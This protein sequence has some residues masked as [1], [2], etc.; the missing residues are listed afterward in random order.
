LR[1]RHPAKAAY[2]DAWNER[3]VAH[4]VRDGE[5]TITLEIGPRAV[6]CVVQAF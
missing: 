6:G 3:P 4:Q 2:M 5:A 1:V